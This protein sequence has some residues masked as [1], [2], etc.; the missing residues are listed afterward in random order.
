MSCVHTYMYPS[1]VF[2]SWAK[3]NK[4]RR[5]VSY[6]CFDQTSWKSKPHPDPSAEWREKESIISQFG[7]ISAHWF[8]QSSKVS[9]VTP[10]CWF[11]FRWFI[12]LVSG[13]HAPE[14]KLPPF[15]PKAG[16]LAAFPQS[17]YLGI[18]VPHP[19]LQIDA[20]FDNMG[21]SCWLVITVSW[22]A[23]RQP[24]FLFMSTAIIGG[25]SSSTR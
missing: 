7:P 25:C 2:S 16:S 21:P 12:L 5:P 6:I 9:L 18:R 20:T 19:V 1:S 15:C 22:L 11:P 4:V 3:G 10:F 17:L 24:A 13:L 23:Q 8:E 14:Q